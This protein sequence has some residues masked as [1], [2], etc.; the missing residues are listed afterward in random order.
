V[1]ILGYGIGTMG[2]LSVGKHAKTSLALSHAQSFKSAVASLKSLSP[3]SSTFT[4][5]SY[6]VFWGI[7]PFR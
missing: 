3:F 5:N 1:G 2:V 7:S 4:A 6:F